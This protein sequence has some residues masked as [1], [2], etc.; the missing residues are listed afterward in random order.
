MFKKTGKQENPEKRRKGNKVSAFFKRAWKAVK[1][2]FLCCDWNRVAPFEPQSD[3]DDFEHLPVPGPFRTVA[4]H[5]DL[6]PVWLPGQV[7]EDPQPLSVPGPFSIKQTADVPNA[8]PARPESSTVLTGHVDPEQMHLPVQV[9]EDPQPLSVPGPFSIKQTADVPDAE[10]ARPES[11]TALTDHVDPEQMHLPVQV[12]EDPQPLSVPGPFSIKQTADVPNA[13][14]AR[15][16]SSTALTDHVDPEQMCPPVQVCDRLESLAVEEPSRIKSTT[17]EDHVDPEQM[18]PGQIFEDPQPLSVPGPSR[19]KQTADPARPESPTALTGHVD[20]ELVC[21]PGQIWEDPQPISVHGLTN[22]KKTTDADSACPESPPSVQ[23]PSKIDGTDEKPKKGRKGKRVSAFFKRVWKAVTRPF[24]CCD[25]DIVQH[26]TPQPE[27]EEANKASGPP[28]GLDLSDFKVGAL[29][30]E[31]GFGQVFV[32]SYKHRKRVKVAL[33]FIN[34]DEDDRYLDTDGHSTPVLAEVAVMLKLA[35]APQCP[36]IIGLHDWVENEN[37][38][39]LSLEYA[40]SY[41]TLEQYIN[42]TFDVGEKR[43]RRLMRQLI[44]AVKFCTE[45]GV[46]HGDIHTQNILVSKSRLQLKLIDFGCAWP[47]TS[48]P[49]DSDDYQGAAI[50]TPPE[51]FTLPIFYA[52][53]VNVWT[54]GIVLYEILHAYMPFTDER[55][56]MFESAEIRPR[57]STEC[58][59]LISQC[60]IRNP[61]NRL[62]LHQV[63]EH[64]WFNPAQQLNKRRKKLKIPRREKHH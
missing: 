19:I 50:C 49:F 37:N 14:P 55:S 54:I 51:V 12:C 23:H 25:T 57:F 47:I 43:A 44:Q 61:V 4:A 28:R 41:Q 62:K 8:E 11:S 31:G 13:E 27:L 17:I 3:V 58:Q 63:E 48:E 40:E 6:E 2:P 32:A 20:T 22:I 16:E 53:P 36:N 29:I 46:F 24:L 26:F 10:P 15:P 1:R 38:F 5:A 42:E 35:N 21:L 34:K 7:C 56:I 33:K 39:I 18:L 52:D 45:R 64:E 30:G 59:D 9:C 60:F